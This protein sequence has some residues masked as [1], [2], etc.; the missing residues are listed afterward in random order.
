MLRR[1]RRGP[2]S[3][4]NLDSWSADGR[5]LYVIEKQEKTAKV[6]RRDLATGRR[7]PWKEITPAD[8]AGFLL[9]NPDTCA[10]QE[11]VCLQLRARSLYPISGPGPEVSFPRV[12]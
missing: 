9:F 10:R 7:E 5:S 12:D 2:P 8:P 6:F 4:A 1:R 11:V 3:R